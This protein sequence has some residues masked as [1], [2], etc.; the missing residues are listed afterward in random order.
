MNLFLRK[1]LSANIRNPERVQDFAKEGY[2]AS[3]VEAFQEHCLQ[4]NYFDINSSFPFSMTFP[5]PGSPIGP[6][7]R[8]MPS[9]ESGE[10]FIAD[11]TIRIEKDNYHPAIPFRGE[12]RRIFFPTGTFQ[13][14]VTQDDL[15]CKGVVIEKVHR[16][17]RFEGRDDLKAFSEDM[18]TMRQ[19]G[20]FEKEVWKIIGNGNYGKWAEREEKQVLL[21][22]PDK[23]DPMTQ[24]TIIPGVYVGTEI[25]RIP[26][27]HV[28]ISMMIT[29]RSRRL[30]HEHIVAAYQKGSVYYC[31]TDSVTCD[32]ELPTDPAL[33]GLKKEF[34]IKRGRFIGAK[35]YA[36]EHEPDEHGNTSKVKAKGF[37]R[38]VSEGGEREGMRYEDFLEMSEGRRVTIERMLRIRELIRREGADY[39]P[40]SIEMQKKINLNLTPKRARLPNGDSRPW[41][42][43]ELGRSAT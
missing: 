8:K 27:R 23:R 14:V 42:V 37:S 5:C 15:K 38:I 25:K 10:L 33:G 31:D 9:L 24:A 22:N 13:T 1:Y 39:M 17:Q 34:T 7:T 40:K 16:V 26:H 28:P 2:V 32:A 4:A 19:K 12:D 29:A 43:S 41:T 3:R 6:V 11:V 35:L 36:I 18:Y 20:G 21:I 30:L